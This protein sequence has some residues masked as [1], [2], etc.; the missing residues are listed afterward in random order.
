MKF[1]L[2]FLEESG[3]DSAIVLIIPDRKPKKSRKNHVY[4]CQN[5]QVN[6]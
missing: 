5:K 6:L 1:S 4:I 2:P 3:T